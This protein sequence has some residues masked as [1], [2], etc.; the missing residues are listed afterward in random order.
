M[1]FVSPLHLPNSQEKEQ[2]S[3]WMYPIVRL[4]F[5]SVV[6]S[7][8]GGDGAETADVFVGNMAKASGGIRTR[9]PS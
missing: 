7:A 2:S 9:V 5:V 1:P 6:N 4:R 8:A 3:R